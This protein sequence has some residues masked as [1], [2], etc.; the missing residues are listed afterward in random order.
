MLLQFIFQIHP[1]DWNFI[2]NNLN[3]KVEVKFMNFH[4]EMLFFRF[5]HGIIDYLNEISHLVKW[6]L[7]ILV[8]SHLSRYSWSIIYY[9]VWNP[10]VLGKKH[11]NLRGLSIW[12]FVVFLWGCLKFA[13]MTTISLRECNKLEGASKFTPW[14]WRLQMRL[15]NFSFGIMLRKRSLHVLIQNYW[16]NIIMRRQR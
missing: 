15:E 12:F 7:G 5:P 4:W 2:G 8:V 1:W 6:E 16:L 14:K 10:S 3:L 11:L 13:R 9:L